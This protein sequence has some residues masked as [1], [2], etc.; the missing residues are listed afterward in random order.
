V[1]PGGCFT[2]RFDPTAAAGSAV[3][4]EAN[5]VVDFVTRAQLDRILN[6]RSNGRLHLDP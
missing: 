4:D 5:S 6:A 2:A 3:V 1:I